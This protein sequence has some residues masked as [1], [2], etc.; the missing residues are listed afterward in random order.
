[1]DYYEIFT[2]DITKDGVKFKKGCEYK[3]LFADRGYEC[4]KN[5]KNEVYFKV[6]EIEPYT[7][8]I[9]K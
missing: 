4:L 6:E 5:G 9:E 2:K 7:E 1:M 3:V 8:I